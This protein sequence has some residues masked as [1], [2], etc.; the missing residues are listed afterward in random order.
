[1]Q[2]RFQRGGPEEGKT[3]ETALALP[4]GM[5]EKFQ[6]RSAAI[7]HI[8][9]GRATIAELRKNKVNQPWGGLHYKTEDT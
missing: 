3:P 4:L 6:T 7:A 1:M 9:Y 2:G 8:Q 5:K